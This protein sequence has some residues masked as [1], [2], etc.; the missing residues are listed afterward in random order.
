[1]SDNLIERIKELE[2]KI[3]LYERNGAAKLYYS[4]NRKMNEMADILNKN[5]LNNIVLDDP[6]DKT[7]DRLKFI[8]NDSAS[9]AAAADTLSKIAKITGNEEEDTAKKPFANLI[10]E[11]RD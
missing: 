9:V 10:A 1:M 8:W 7:F 4:L 5:N 2:Q 11:K 3:A 6:K